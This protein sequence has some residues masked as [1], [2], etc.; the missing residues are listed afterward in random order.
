MKFMIGIYIR[1]LLNGNYKKVDGEKEEDEINHILEAY[2][3]K[4]KL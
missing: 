4:T 1:A 2:A 3:A